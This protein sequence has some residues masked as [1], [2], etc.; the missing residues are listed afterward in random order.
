MSH[1]F[2]TRAALALCFSAAVLPNFAQSGAITPDMLSNF[3][4]SVP[5]NPTSKALQNALIT[6]GVAALAARPNVAQANDTY[7]SNEA[8]SK[9]ITDQQSSGRCWLFT[10]LNVMR[11]HMIREQKLGRFEFSQS[12]NSFYDQLEKSNLFLQ[13]IIDKANKRSHC[14]LVVPQSHQRWWHLH[15]CARRHQ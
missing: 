14:G 10:G 9:G 1:H 11:S 2:L 15:W 4:K 6:S 12:Y 5:N 13:S 7:F 3:R 8:P